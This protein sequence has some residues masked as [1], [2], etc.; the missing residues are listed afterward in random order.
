MSFG[1]IIL[2][3]FLPPLAVY[4]KTGET[5]DLLINLALT[6]FGFGLIG[7]IHAFIVVSRV[8]KA[9]RLKEQLEPEKIEPLAESK[10]APEEK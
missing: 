6:F 4:L 7:I 9:K 5:K 1:Y 8:E 2:C 10:T 3:I